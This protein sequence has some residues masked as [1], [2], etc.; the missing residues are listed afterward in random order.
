MR[1]LSGDG[2][3]PPSPALVQHHRW[4]GAATGR[5]RPGGGHDDEVAGDAT[6]PD[7]LDT[8]E[9]ALAN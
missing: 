7:E 8:I 6:T 9:T 1:V 3:G 4:V 2:P 5:T